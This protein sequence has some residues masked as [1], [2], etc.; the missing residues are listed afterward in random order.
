MLFRPGA[1]DSPDPVSRALHI[2]ERRVQVG[3]ATIHAVLRKL[4][5]AKLPVIRG[6]TKTYVEGPVDYSDLRTQVIGLIYEGLLDYRLKRTDDSL[7][8][9]VFLNIGRQPVLP[10]RRLEDMLAN[11]RNGL[12]NLL[13]TLRKEQVTASASDEDEGSDEASEDAEQPD[14]PEEI[15][16]EEPAGD[17]AEPGEREGARTGAY[18][19]AEDAAKRWAREAVVLAGLVGKQRKK[20]TDA[21]YHNRIESE[22][23]RLI[24]RVTVLGEFYLVRAGN[25]RKG[26]G[27]F[28][29]RPELAVPTVYRALEPLCYDKGENGT[30]TPKPPETIL[31]LKV[32]DPACGSASFLVASLE[33]LTDALYRS[34]CVHRR[35]DDPEVANRLTLPL[36]QPRTGRL[37]EDLVKFPPN[38]PYHGDNF[39]AWVKARLR[40]YVVERCVYGV[41][42]NPLAVELARVSL[43]IA[44][45]DP[46]LPFSFLDHKIKVGNA[47]VGCWLDRVEDY[48][49][50]AWEREGGDGKDGPRS[51]RI[52]T[53][54]KGE[55]VG[56][57]RPGDGRIKREMR[58]LIESR[59]QGYRTFLDGPDH[60]PLDVV[61]RLRDEYQ[62][63]HEQPI[64]DPEVQEARFR[65]IEASEARQRLKRA[66]DEWCAVW[67]WPMDEASFSHVPTPASFHAEPSPVRSFVISHLSSDLKFFHWELEYPDV[68]TPERSGFDA[69]VGNPPWDVMKPNSQEFFSDFDPLYRTYDKQAA[70]RKQ[71]DLFEGV[72]GVA[73]QWDEYN[74]R[75][76]ALGNWAR[77]VAEPFDLALAKGKD[78]SALAAVWAKRRQSRQGF[79]DPEHPFRLQGSADLNS[80]KMFAEVFWTLIKHQGRIGVILPTGLYSDFGTKDLRETLL[81]R[82]RIDLLYA[83]QNE[84]RV[85]AAADHS[86]KQVA[87]F[88]SKGG[89]TGSFR[90]RF[91]M[92][93][94]DSPEAHEL[95]DDI[96]RNDSAA[97]VFTPED[98]RRNSPKSLSLVELRSQRD[99]DIFRKIY[100]HS[101]RIG[102]NA[103][104]WEIT[105]ATEF[106]MTNDS[107]LFPPL[108]QWEAKGYRPDVFGRWIG[109][110]GDVALPFY[111]G[112]MVGQFDFLTMSWVI[113]LGNAA[114]WRELGFD[115]KIFRP[116]ALIGEADS[117]NGGNPY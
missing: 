25:T 2:L 116:R 44:T 34:L 95:P 29:T 61:A 47:L 76:K 27:T 93:V 70:L 92:G 39:E 5:R 36:G 88:A 68:F 59:F 74:A 48:P 102:D 19:A 99:L 4:L 117:W 87:V 9:M 37:N 23:T 98:V 113:G 75:F 114:I 84:K 52:E 94:G 77:N 57:R 97:M 89:T 50:K 62:T 103:P 73:D 51:Q 72:S 22:A 46:G 26:S 78:G 81:N 109:P 90:S 16:E 110:D 54:L 6:R 101:I 112:R 20:E 111:E 71:R 91:R 85:F 104:G 60:R 17:E 56:N 64:Q 28:Y 105:Y 13:T 82:G 42:I 65:E 14:E 83:F 7:G 69:L 10:L 24:K 1:P 63:L 38:D 41:D 18:L 12:K 86:Y 79:A 3:D 100:D 11:D 21:E 31:G 49:L 45:L 55:K 108:E 106:H 33:Y 35:L 8:P 67:F 66:M 58:E 40:R 43:W 96:L 80:Y 107:K 15:V 32:C 30:L 53:L 115:N